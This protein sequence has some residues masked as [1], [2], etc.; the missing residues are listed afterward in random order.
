MRS[1]QGRLGRLAGALLAAIWVSAAAAGEDAQPEPTAAASTAPAVVEFFEARVRPILAERC[2]KCHGERKQ[3][4]GLRLDSRAAILQGGENGPAVVPGQPEQSLL[5]QAVSHRHDELKMPP[6]GKLPESDIALLTR[7]VALGA[8]W[9]AGAGRGLTAAATVT[10]TAKAHW[11]FQPVR[12]VS[13]APVKDRNWVRSP[14]D[15]FILARLES[16]GLDPS[17]PADKRTLIRRATLD[18]WGIPPSPEEVEAFEADPA[19]DAFARLVDRLL[20]SPRYGERWGRHWLD[21]A[22]YADTKGYVFTQERRYPYAFTYRDYVIDAFNA[23]LGFDR[24]ILE[25]LAADQLPR[26]SDSRALAA[27][28]FLTVGRRFLLDQNE[29]IDD[30]IDVV[31]RGLLG[32]TVTCARCHDHKFDPIPTEDYYSL[33]GVFASSIEPDELPMLPRTGPATSPQSAEFERKLAAARKKREAFLSARRDELQKDLAARFS[34]YLK[35]ASDLGFDPRNPRLEERAL[36]SQLNS[37]RLRG[38]IMT[39]KRHLEATR[40]KFDPVLT[41]WHVFSDLPRDGFAAK[42]A[43]AIDEHPRLAGGM[44]FHPLV[45]RTVLAGPTPS[46]MAE[47]I[48]RYVGLFTQL[49]ARVQ[50]QAARSGR[51]EPDWESLRQAIFGPS[52]PLAASTDPRRLFLDQRQRQQLGNLDGAIE[53]LNA[54]DPAAPSRAMVL[55]DAPRPVEPHVFIRGNPSRPGPAVPRRFLRVLAGPAA[56]PFR[57]GSG[58]L[59]LARAIADP[60]NPM[61]ARVLVNRVWHWHFGR[62]L[63]GTPSDFGLRSDPPT[64]PELLDFLAGEF[65]ASGWSIKALHRRILLSATYQQRSDPRPGPIE[66]DPENR[67]LWRFSPRRLDFEAMRD[68]L[69]AVSGALD[70]AMGGRPVMITAAPFSTR[71]TVYGFIDRQNLD[72]LYRTFDFAVPDATSPRR[73]VTTVPQQALFLMNSPFLHQQARRLAGAIAPG[74]S[75]DPAL[76][77]RQLYRRVLGRVPQPDEVSLA[78]E[79]LRRQ[80]DGSGRRLDSWKRVPHGQIAKAGL[81]PPMAPWEQLAQVLLLTNEFMF[82]E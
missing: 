17:P 81:D 10:S 66:R 72:G 76:A 75:A 24:F 47:V 60:R 49:E 15:T 22:R 41:P 20:A 82:V 4:S 27:M 48:D 16:A 2:Q 8:P 44:A 56:A 40:G 23:D 32:L 35:A 51:L 69:L 7:W 65:L 64:H 34:Q 50:E 63:V 78:L 9:P 28:G 79:F 42:A 37:R 74:D 54:T 62:G 13:P 14:I 36:A 21:V 38:V 71:R 70:P 29:I 68:S 58:R 61:T 33:Y 5:I 26:G 73:F 55:N 11:A 57:Q 52:G 31:C 3:S 67:L 18:L 30:R 6:G 39:W 77:V 12:P 80:S 53:R 1:R 19:P 45:A 25:Q 59:E 43:A 46:S